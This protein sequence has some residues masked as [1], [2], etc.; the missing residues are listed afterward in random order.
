VSFESLDRGHRR[1]RITL[2][3]YGFHLLVSLSHPWLP[4]LNWNI[5]ATLAPWPLLLNLDDDRWRFSRGVVDLLALN[6]DWVTLVRCFVQ[7]IRKVLKFGDQ[8]LL[9]LL[10]LLFLLILQPLSNFL[11]GWCR[12]VCLKLHWTILLLLKLLVVG[13]ELSILFQRLLRRR[14]RTRGCGVHYYNLRDVFLFCIRSHV[15]VGA[16]LL[17]EILVLRQRVIAL[18]ILHM[19]RSNLLAQPVVESLWNMFKFVFVFEASA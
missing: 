14:F 8:L 4:R 19:I 15:C 6:L 13:V 9:H 11:K 12:Q 2:S 5:L 10:G 1:T 16:F 7:I 17:W 18:S 3:S